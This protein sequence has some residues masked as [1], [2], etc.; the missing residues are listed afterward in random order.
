M[1]RLLVA[2]L[3]SCSATAAVAQD[4]PTRP[5]RIVIPFAAGG[6]SDIVARA[7]AEP[8]SKALGQ[9]IV[10]EN[11]GGAG[12]TIA[13]MELSRA[14][15]DGY[16]LMLGTAGNLAMAPSLYRSP[17]YDPQ[18]DLSPVAGV[19]RGQFVLVVNPKVPAASVRELIDLARTKPGALAY[20]SSG[21]G[22]PPHLA[23]EMFK[24]LARIDIVHVPYK[25]SA[26]MMTDLIGGQTQLAFDSVA[27]AMPHV[28]AGRLKALATTGTARAPATPELPTMVE[29]GIADYDLTSFYAVVAPAGTPPAIV[30]RLAAEIV[31]AAN[32]AEVRERLT[33]AGLEP[34]AL[35]SGELGALMQRERARYAKLIAAAGIHPE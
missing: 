35:E 18:R 22:A 24:S 31:R 33:A 2:L 32:S 7:V 10:I 29:A 3:A 15:P 30:S 16:T 28:R 27:T 17:G 14:A 19:A 34:A 8:M 25:G 4:F 13:A 12:G 6:V 21:T 26:P 5:I 11:K 20:A 1:K 9:P 23:G